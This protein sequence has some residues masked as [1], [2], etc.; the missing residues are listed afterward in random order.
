MANNSIDWMALLQRELEKAGPKGKVRVAA[1]LGV[2]RSYVSR[3]MN[4]D[5]KSAMKRVPQEFIDRVIARFHVT[6]CPQRGD[7]EVPYSDCTKAN[8][9]APTHNPLAVMLWRKCQT[10]P[11]KPTPTKGGKQ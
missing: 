5:G 1:R 6:T 8:Q 4:Q 2:S 9:P 7:L 11:N 10:C 3:V